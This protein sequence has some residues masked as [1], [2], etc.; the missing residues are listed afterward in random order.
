MAQKYNRIRLAQVRTFSLGTFFSFSLDRSPV[1]RSHRAN[2]AIGRTQITI[3]RT[4][5]SA[6]RKSPQG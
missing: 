2:V 6:I 1:A 4:K 3:I 5:K